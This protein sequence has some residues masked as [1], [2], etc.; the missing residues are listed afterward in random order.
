MMRGEGEGVARRGSTPQRDGVGARA[1]EGGG[2]CTHR[3]WSAR[4]AQRG[5]GGGGAAEGWAT[6]GAAGVNQ[7]GAGGGF[8]VKRAPDRRAPDRRAPSAR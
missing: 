5:S 7:E 2:P 6:E 8:G 4:N 3:A 1:G